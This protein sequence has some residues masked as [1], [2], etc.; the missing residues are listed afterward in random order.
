[1]AFAQQPQKSAGV[2]VRTSGDPMGIASAVRAE[3]RKLDRAQ[4]IF[5]MKSMDQSIAEET[6]GVRSAAISMT[7][8]AAIALLLAATGIYAI[9][10]YSVQQRTHEIGIRMALGADRPTILKMTLSG[11]LRIG[12]IGL[13]IGIPTAFALVQ[14]MSS[15]LYGV[16]RLEALTFVG[17]VAVLAASAI[18]AGYLPALRAARLD[19]TEALREE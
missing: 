15:V 1:M 8:Y 2:F 14:I 4:P 19:P 9:I 11:A 5:D 13:A 16:V 7:I 18:A 6:S 10:S 17:G 12:G 3:V